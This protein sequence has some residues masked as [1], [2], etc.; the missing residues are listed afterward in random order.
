VQRFTPEFIDAGRPGR[1]VP[2]DRSFLDE[3]YIKVAGP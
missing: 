1:H 2:G 3:T